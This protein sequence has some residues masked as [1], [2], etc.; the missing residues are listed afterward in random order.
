MEDLKT[1][2]MNAS[3]Q[4][5]IAKRNGQLLKQVLTLEEA[6]ERLNQGKGVSTYSS[7]KYNAVFFTDDYCMAVGIPEMKAMDFGPSS[8]YLPMNVVKRECLPDGIVDTIEK[9]LLIFEKDRR[10]I[11]SLDELVEFLSN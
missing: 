1:R 9:Y 6:A 2:L 5:Q 8:T 7:N 4:S 3:T 10:V 11:T